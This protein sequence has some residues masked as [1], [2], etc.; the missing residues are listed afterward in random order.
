M[1]PRGKC[2]FRKTTL[3]RAIQTIEGC[4]KRI[5]R[6]EIDQEGRIVILTD[7]PAEAPANDLDNWIAQRADPA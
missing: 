2:A 1:A 4:G 6:V 3:K 5:S 7:K